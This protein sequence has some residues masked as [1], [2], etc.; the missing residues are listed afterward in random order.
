MVLRLKSTGARLMFATTTPFPDGTLPVRVPAD[1]ALYN[2]AARSVMAR[3]GVAVNDLGVF[4][5]PHLAEW[6]LPANVHFKSVGSDRLAME[7][8]RRIWQLLDRDPA[9]LPA[10]VPPPA[11]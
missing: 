10:S 1:A 4:A 6:Q 9:E 11:K 3:H 5:E 7:V 8:A 2:E